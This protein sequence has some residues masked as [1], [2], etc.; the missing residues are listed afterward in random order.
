MEKYRNNSKGVLKKQIRMEKNNRSSSMHS[1]YRH[2]ILCTPNIKSYCSLVL[3]ND[4]YTN[5]CDYNG[6]IEK[7]GREFKKNKYKRM[8]DSFIKDQI[9]LGNADFCW[10]CGCSVKVG[11]NLTVD[12]I[13]S[14]DN[15]GDWYNKDN[16]AICCRSCNEE[17]GNKSLEEFLEGL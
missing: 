11:V 4:Y 10:Y 7:N 2:N 3:L 14:K 13:V 16:F 9:R 5:Y 17:K 6:R 15:D 8:R 12:H 1:L